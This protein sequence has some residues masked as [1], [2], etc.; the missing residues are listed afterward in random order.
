MS[1]AKVKKGFDALAFKEQAQARIIAETRGMSHAE[2]IEY[3]R[4]SAE[5]GP[6]GEWWKRVKR[7]TEARRAAGKPSKPQLH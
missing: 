1:Q 5:E 3:F 6:M 4:R 7:E 2:E